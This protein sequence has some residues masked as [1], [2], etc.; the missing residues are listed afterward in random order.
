[1]LRS[2]HNVSSLSRKCWDSDR[3]VEQQ[4]QR[5]K[6]CPPTR[7]WGFFFLTSGSKSGTPGRAGS[8]AGSSGHQAG[9]GVKVPTGRVVSVKPEVSPPLVSSAFF[10]ARSANRRLSLRRA[11]APHAA[12]G[13]VVP[14]VALQ[15]LLRILV[16]LRGPLEETRLRRHAMGQDDCGRS[17]WGGGGAPVLPKGGLPSTSTRRAPPGSGDPQANPPR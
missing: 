4:Q 13:D 9:S 14:A 6:S 7:L 2:R 3:K 5:G 12:F 1:M 15:L 10:A 16:L 8:V 17:V 11:L